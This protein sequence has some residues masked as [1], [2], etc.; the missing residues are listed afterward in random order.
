MSLGST[1]TTGFLANVDDEKM[2]V[3][4]KSLL[5]KWVEHHDTGSEAPH[6]FETVFMRDWYKNHVKRKQ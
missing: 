3:A 1:G 2:L 4:F 5:W 6:H